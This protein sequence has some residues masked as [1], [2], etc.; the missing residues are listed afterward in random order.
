MQ[1]I[2]CLDLTKM[3]N[4]FS[5]EE[6]NGYITFKFPIY[7]DGE[8]GKTLK[9]SATIIGVLPPEGFEDILMV[10]KHTVDGRGS[11]KYWKEANLKVRNHVCS[12]QVNLPPIQ[13]GKENYIGI[14]EEDGVY[15]PFVYKAEKVEKE[16]DIIENSKK[17]ETKL[18]YYFLNDEVYV[19]TAD[20]IKD[21]MKG[22]LP[23]IPEVLEELKIPLPFKTTSS[24]L[25][26]RLPLSFF[27]GYAPLMYFDEGILFN[28]D[29]VT[30][31]SNIIVPKRRKS[32]LYSDKKVMNNGYKTWN[33]FVYAYKEEHPDI[34]KR[35]K[36]NQQELIGEELAEFEEDVAVEITEPTEDHEVLRGLTGVV[37]G[38]R[39]DKVLVEFLHFFKEA[40]RP[41]EL[42]RV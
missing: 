31:S 17:K 36:I 3:K 32:V 14:F 16:A 42:K 25:K 11:Q 10:I 7:I 28:A 6:V 37:K 1:K 12:F 38:K 5:Y 24:E 9:L 33:Q 41:S 21:A 27:K 40:F 15:K 30:P 4:R 19:A 18:H 29:Y 26:K 13:S 22:P 23:S 2:S 35:I 39:G 8:T 34:E 20:P